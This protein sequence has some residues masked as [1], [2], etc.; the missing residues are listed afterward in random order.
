MKRSESD[1]RTYNIKNNRVAV[2]A[3]SDKTLPMGSTF[4]CLN[5]HSVFSTKKR[6]S[7][8]TPDIRER[9][10]PYMA[11]IAK[12]NG[13]LPKCIGGVADHVHLLLGLPTTMAIAK[14]IQLIKA[15]S[16]GWIHN[17]FPE[18]RNFA[19]QQGYGAFSIGVAELPETIHYIERQVEHHRARTFK[20][21]YLA[22]LKRHGGNLD[23]KYLWD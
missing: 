20:E 9:L 18:L 19:W 14:A 21:E 23:E 11:G 2:P 15:G 6:A 12:Q 13:I 7:V 5:I 3:I 22:F 16:S 4:S 1:R 17:T 8:L 10:W